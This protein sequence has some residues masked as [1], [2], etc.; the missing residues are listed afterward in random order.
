MAA[1]SIFVRMPMLRRRA[2]RFCSTIASFESSIIMYESGSFFALTVELTV[3]QD[4]VDT[5]GCA[6]IN[7]HKY[8]GLLPSSRCFLP[9]LSL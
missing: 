5:L 7:G 4:V 9:S 8:G 2:L 3:D 6:G 1:S